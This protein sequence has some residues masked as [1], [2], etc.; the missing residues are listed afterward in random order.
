MN[1]FYFRK[2][3]QVNILRGKLQQAEAALRQAEEKTGRKISERRGI[4]SLK[5]QRY[6]LLSS[7]WKQGLKED[8]N[9]KE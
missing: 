9:L 8:K 6:S 1:N 2:R 3:N 4:P 7:S 5:E